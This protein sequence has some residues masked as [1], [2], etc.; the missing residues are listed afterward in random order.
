M[1]SFSRDAHND[2]L[3]PPIRVRYFYSSPLTIDDPLSAVPPPIASTATPVRHAPRPFSKYDNRLLNEAWEDIYRKRATI[4]VRER[5]EKQDV[6]EDTQRRDS[7]IEPTQ[8]SSAAYVTSIEHR[9]RSLR[10]PKGQ[11]QTGSTAWDTA[12]SSMSPKASNLSN[13]DKPRAS[14]IAWRSVYANK[15]QPSSIVGSPENH[16]F[17]EDGSMLDVEG[18][19]G[20]ITGTPFIRAPSRTKVQTFKRYEQAKSSSRP[21]SRGSIIDGDDDS[22]EETVHGSSQIDDVVATVAVGVSRLHQVQLPQLR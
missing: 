3:P 22:P 6:V 15:S 13:M 21:S 11:G 2:E 18:D 5:K 1:K 12:G 7:N 16:T 19:T 20:G 9:F 14:S 4:R 10:I 8:K 17:R